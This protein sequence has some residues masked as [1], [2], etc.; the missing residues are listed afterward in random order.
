MCD[1]ARSEFCQALTSDWAG[2]Y[3]YSS[4]KRSASWLARRAR[5][6]SPMNSRKASAI[7]AMRRHSEVAVG[8]IMGAGIYNL[9]AIMGLVALVMPIPVPAQI[10][11]FDLW[12][13]LA[14]T[15]GVSIY[16][17][18][19]PRFVGLL[20]AFDGVYLL[21]LHIAGVYSFGEAREGRLFYA[22]RF[23][24]ALASVF[25]LLTLALAGLGLLALLAYSVARARF[26]IGIRQTL[27]AT[28]LR[29]VGRVVGRSVALVG[30]GLAIGFGLTLVTG[31]LLAGL[32]YGVGTADPAAF[33]ATAAVLLGGALL[34][35]AGPAR[36]A[37]RVPP[38]TV[39]RGG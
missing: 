14:V 4:K 16:L 37:A 1:I 22:F 23:L 35:S 30:A 8:N 29:I 17:D 11:A 18:L 12:F 34:A 33:A 38:A 20:L 39:L 3:L 7:S 10:L 28:R 19:A 31:R 32:L 25:T 9:L 15:A 6:A 13:M 5:T 24:V 26:E 36:S 27:G 2:L 21:A